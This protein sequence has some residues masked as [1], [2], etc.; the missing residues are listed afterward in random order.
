MLNTCNG[1]FWMQTLHNVQT[2]VLFNMFLLITNNTKTITALQIIHFTLFSLHRKDFPQK[3]EISLFPYYHLCERID[4]FESGKFHCVYNI[5]YVDVM[6]S[7]MFWFED[8]AAIHSRARGQNMYSDL[9]LTSP[10]KLKIH[11]EWVL[12]VLSNIRYLEEQ[13]Q[14]RRWN[15]SVI[16]NWYSKES[17]LL[18][19]LYS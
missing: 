17:T 10:F 11:H 15:L 12:L 14:A 7:L 13:M 16:F 19:C 1:L 6:K 2:N 8:K 9:W 3:N 4:H 5:N 18:F